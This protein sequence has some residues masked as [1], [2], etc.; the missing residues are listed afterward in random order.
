MPTACSATGPGRHLAANSGAIAWGAFPSSKRHDERAGTAAAGKAD[1]REV[2]AEPNLVDTANSIILKGL[3]GNPRYL[4]LP[5]S[6]RQL[7]G[8]LAINRAV[9]T[10]AI[11]RA[12]HFQASDSGSRYEAALG[13]I[14]Q[15]P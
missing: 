6:G 3:D 12:I 11:F 8:C 13:L 4:P 15:Y 7:P 1:T 5:P 2:A 14:G 10:A 9:G